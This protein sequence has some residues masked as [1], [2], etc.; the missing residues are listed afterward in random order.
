MYAIIIAVVVTLLAILTALRASR[1]VAKSAKELSQMSSKLKEKT[2]LLEKEQGKIVVLMKNIED[3]ILITERDKIVLLNPAAERI[4]GV[5]KSRAV[6]HS[7]IEVAKDPEMNEILSYCLQTGKQNTKTVE[8]VEKQFFKVTATP[9]EG[10]S[11]II[12]EDLTEMKRLEAVHRD[13]IG[14]I[15]HELR[16]PLSSVKLLTETL[17]RGAIEDPTASTEFLCSI[18]IEVDKLTQMVTELGDLSRLESGDVPFE[19]KPIFIDE[20]VN[21][22]SERMRPQS[23]RAGLELTLN[24]SQNLPQV[25]A[26]EG[27]IEQVL[28]NLLHNAVK[29]TSPGGKVSVSAELQKGAVAISVADTGIGIS[30]DD[31]PRIFERFYKV[32]K[33]RGTGGTGL[34]LAIAKHIV[35]THGGKIGAESKEGKGSTFFFTLPA[36]HSS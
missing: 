22:A 31:L 26:D 19:K 1:S 36:M 29:F 25:L 30:E 28:V 6:G 21:R 2:Q 17:Q 15:S 13:F 5:P 32:S 27:R 3:G 20:V 14:N 23:E 10:G 11:L 7:F 34:G 33:S 12:L 18:K 4:F 9:I 16:T 24:I 35:E 8:R